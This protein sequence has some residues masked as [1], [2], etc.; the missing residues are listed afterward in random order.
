MSTFSQ[1]KES[2]KSGHIDKPSFVQAMYQ[3]HAVR[4]DGISGAAFEPIPATYSHLRRNF[5]LNGVPQIIAHFHA[6]G[7][8]CFVVRSQKLEPCAAVTPSTNE[9]NFIFLHL[10]K[11][12]AILSAL[13]T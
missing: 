8:G 12:A 7:Y 2:Y 13:A 11:H 5:D 9:T 6:K 1:I 4:F 10:E 3:H